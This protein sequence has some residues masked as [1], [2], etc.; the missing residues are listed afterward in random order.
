MPKSILC[1][2][3]DVGPIDLRRVF[4]I[5]FALLLLCP[6]MGIVVQWRVHH[7]GEASPVVDKRNPMTPEKSTIQRQNA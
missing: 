4:P 1:Y 5:D 7:G 3:V 2:G 6:A